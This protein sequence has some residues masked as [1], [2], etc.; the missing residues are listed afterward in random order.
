MRIVSDWRLV[1]KVY[2]HRL[3]LIANAAN[4]DAP[5]DDTAIDISAPWYS[6]GLY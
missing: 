2:Q 6:L 3:E 1:V 4:N 5:D